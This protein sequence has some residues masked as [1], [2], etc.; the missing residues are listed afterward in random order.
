[1]IRHKNLKHFKGLKIIE[2]T[3]D[4]EVFLKKKHVEE[5]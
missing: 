3:N 4:Y 2:N 1:V 5:A